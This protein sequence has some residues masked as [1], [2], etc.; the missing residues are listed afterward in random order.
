[1]KFYTYIKETIKKNIPYQSFYF[2]LRL[3]NL[4]HM[5]LKCSL[6]HY[7]ITML[8]IMILLG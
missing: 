2:F 3:W 5:I 6:V 4:D 8:M 1:M 7:G